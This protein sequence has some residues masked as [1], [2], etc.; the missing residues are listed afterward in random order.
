MKGG[1]VILD[2]TLFYPQGGGQ[3]SDKGKLDKEGLILKV[4]TVFKE[5]NDI[6]HQISSSV[7][8]KIKIGDTVTGEIDW[9][10]RYGLMRAHSSQHIL[11]ALI[12]NNFDIDTAHATISFED[13]S[14]QIARDISDNQFKEI[15]SEFVK[16]CTIEN[17]EFLTNL[18]SRDEIKSLKDKVRGKVPNEGKVRLVEL[19]KYDLIC[20]G[21]THVKNSTEIGPVFIYEFSKGKNFKYKVGLSA[22][23]QFTSD[24]IDALNYSRTLNIPATKLI[25]NFQKQIE[26]KSVLQQNYINLATAALKLV[27]QHPNTEVNNVKVGLIAI[28]LDYKLI[29]KQFKEFPEEYL[30]IIKEETNK[31]H[32]LSNTDKAQANKI[33][34]PFLKKYGGKGGGS[35]YSAQGTLKDDPVDILSELSF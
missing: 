17:H 33:L 8:S 11:S 15:L 19:K 22:L 28:D 7:E 4:E 9:N 6:I 23:N 24:N 16:I 27:S 1:G 5:G 29:Q 32:L 14:L 34:E 21:G 2:R 35:P 30:L 12:K 25:R 20:C 26:K 3:V 31:I 10:Y 13:I 18:I